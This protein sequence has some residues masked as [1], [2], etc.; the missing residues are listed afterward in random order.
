MNDSYYTM[1]TRAGP[2]A[3]NNLNS[4]TLENEEIRT[5][6]PIKS[7]KTFG[8]FLKT[9]LLA[10]TVWLEVIYYFFRDTNEALAF[11]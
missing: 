9:K 6:A 7:L 8:M 3:R 2:L 5:T 1:F 4:R 10:Y 11:A